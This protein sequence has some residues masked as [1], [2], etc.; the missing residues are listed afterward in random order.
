MGEKIKTMANQQDSRRK[1]IKKVTAGS[2]LVM[3]GGILPAFSAQSYRRIL[4]ANE[5]INASVMGVNSR[6]NALA[7]NFAAQDRCDVIHICDVDSRAT[8]K[9]ISGLQE[10]QKLKAKGFAANVSRED[11]AKGLELIG[12][13]ADE[14]F[15]FLIKV[16]S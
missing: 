14:H 7:R 3:A 16:F 5:T 4:G 13:T 2:G 11:I 12:K 6:G 8:D 10:R 15:A 9:C 1:F